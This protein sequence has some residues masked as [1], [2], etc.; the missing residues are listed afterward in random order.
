[1]PS[2]Q[3]SKISSE[4]FGTF[5]RLAS[6]LVTR[7]ANLGWQKTVL[8]SSLL[9]L[10]VGALLYW[11]YLLPTNEVMDNLRRDNAGLNKQIAIAQTVKQT[12]PAFIEEYRR[13]KTIYVA[14]R[15]LLP[16]NTELSKVMGVIQD[17]ARRNNVRITLFDASTPNVK[18]AIGNPPAAPPAAPAPPNGAT[19][20]AALPDPAN[21]NP[22][23]DVAQTRTVLNERVI[24]A[25]LVGKHSSI[26][27]FLR[28][29]AI[30]ELII[31]VRDLKMTAINKEVTVNMKL[32]AFDAPPTSA[33]PADPPE[34][35][36]QA[37]ATT[38]TKPA[39]LTPA[40]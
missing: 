37:S 17:I 3:T 16:N 39:R 18:S 2:Q 6:G 4:K 10:A 11:T 31:G 19:P 35:A 5:G 8:F 38:V 9:A 20:P 28:E 26:K 21:P 30:Y 24:P 25:Q 40:N 23:P 14:A 36:Q 33:L 13:G 1:M 34:L 7:A 12:R 32:V 15:D 29:L 27:D 22:Q